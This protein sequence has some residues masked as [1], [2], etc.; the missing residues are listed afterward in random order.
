MDNDAHGT[1]L[2]DDAV[3]L[4][5]LLPGPIERVWRYLTEPALRRQWLADG[6]FP[7]DAG[8]GF[9]LTFRNNS[10]TRADDPPPAR[11]AGMAELA[12]TRGHLRACSPPHRLVIT[13]DEDAEGNGSEVSFELEPDGDEVLLTL[14]H[15]RLPRRSALVSVSSGWHAHL[16]VLHA[17][18]MDTDPPPFWQTF[19]RLEQDY[20]Q[21]IPTPPSEG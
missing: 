11:Y 4:Q 12:H 1:L 6:P 2:G 21:R 5:R 13:W 3:R 18:L 17:R 7:G 10:L 19:S 20:E 14:T 15:Q 8:E 9:E 16:G